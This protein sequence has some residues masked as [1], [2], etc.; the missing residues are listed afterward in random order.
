MSSNESFTIPD[1]HPHEQVP[2]VEPTTPHTTDILHEIRSANAQ[3]SA[4]LSARLDGLNLRLGDVERHYRMQHSQPDS[5]SPAARSLPPSSHNVAITARLTSEESDNQDEVPPATLNLQRGAHRTRPDAPVPPHMTRAAAALATSV[6]SPTPR[7]I[8]TTALSEL[9]PLG[10]YRTMTKSEKSN[11]RRALAGIGLTVSTLAALV[12]V[13]EDDDDLSSAAGQADNNLPSS[14][15]ASSGVASLRNNDSPIATSSAGPTTNNIGIQASAPDLSANSFEQPQPTIAMQPSSTVPPAITPMLH[16]DPAPNIPVQASTSTSLALSTRSMTCKT[17][18][19]GDYD[20]DPTQLEDFLTRLRDLIRSET[21]EELIPVWIKAV[22]RTLPRTFKSNAAVWHQGL[23]DTDAA[24]LTSFEAWATAMRAAFPVNRQQ[25]RRDA[26]LRKWK[27]NE[28]NA[29]GYYFHKVRLLRQAFGK[30]QQEEALVTDIVDGLPETM[31]ALLRLPRKGAT[32]AELVMELGDWEPNWRVQYK[33]PLRSTIA[34]ATTFPATTPTTPALAF[35]PT[36][37]RLIQQTMGRSASAP[38]TPAATNSLSSRAAPS[39]SPSQKPISKFA[40]AYDPTRVIP[41]QNGQPR[42]YRPPGKDAVMDL[43]APCS[44]C[45]GDHFNFEHDHLVPQVR[46]LVADDDDYEEYTWDGDN[47]ENGDGGNDEPSLSLESGIAPSMFTVEASDEIKP[48]PSPNDDVAE[49]GLFFTDRS[50]F[51]VARTLRPNEA[52]PPLAQEK[53][54]FG[55]VVSLSKQGATGTGQG[56][57]NHVPLTTHVRI[58]DTDGRAMSSLLDTGASL[59]CIDATLLEKMG[60]KPKGEPMSVHGIGSSRTLGW[61]TLPLFIAAQDPMGKH[62]HLEV[63]HDFHVLPFFPPGLCLGLDFIDAH[64]ISISPVRGRARLG[65]YTFQVHEKLDKPF[66]AE[67]EL[68]TSTDITIAPNTQAWVQVNAAIL[69]PD[70]DYIAVPRFSATPD[71]SV[72]LTGPNGLITHGAVRQ[73]LIGNYG[74]E[75]F[76][77]EKDTIIAD[78]AAA[79]VGD[80]VSAAG[81]TFTLDPRLPPAD[82]PPPPTRPTTTEDAAMPFDPFEDLDA[83]GPSLAQDAATTLVDGAFKVGLDA[84]GNAHPEIVQLLQDQKAAF[85]LDGRPGRVEGHDM[86]IH[87]KPDAAM[88]SE[89]PRRASPEKRA[90]MDAAIDQLLE[91]DVIEASDSPVSFPVVMVKQQS[92]WRFCVDYRNLN[93]D[94]IPDRYPLPTID[95]I[96]HTLCGKKIFSSLDA[97]RGYHQLGVQ[98]EDR[99]KTAFVCHRGLF[100]YK[101]IPFGLRNAP[102]F[103]QRFMDKV[104]GPLR[105][106]QAVVYIDDSVVAT[107][108]MAEH[109]SALRQLFQSA[110]SVGLKFSPAKCTFAVPSLVLLGRKVSGAGVAIWK[111]RAQAVEH[112]A[113]PTTLQELYHTLGL[114]GYYR[115]FIP[116]FAA[117]ASPLTALLKGW[118]YETS[119]GQSRLVNTE[120]KA[121]TASRIP[122]AWDS[123]Q[124]A[125][126][127]ALKAAITTPPVLAH[128]DP[129]KPYI[130]YTDA[131]KDALGAILHQV[132]SDPLP[133]TSSSEPGTLHVMSSPLLPLDV[134]RRSWE[135]WLTADPYFGPILRQVRSAPTPDDEWVL[136]DGV[137]VRRLDDCVALPVAAVPSVMRAV[138]D[139]RGHFGFT[140]TLLAI[141]RHFWRPSLSST[142]RA[143]VKHCAVCQRIK[144]V[145]KVGSL[146]ISNDPTSPLEAISFDLIYGFPRAQSGNDAVLAIHCLFSRMLL[147][148]PCHKDITAEGVAAIVADRV[149]RLG[150]RPKR[151]VADSEAR[152]S[153]AVMASLAS[154]LG[155]D[156]TPSSPHHQQ[157]NAVE[158]AIQTAQQ[159]LQVMAVD[160]K[161]HW[162]KRILPAVELAINS[163]PSLTTGFRP[164]DLV[165]L[166]HPDVVHALFDSQEHLGVHSFDERLAAGA[167]R[168]QEAYTAIN[169]ARKDQRRYDSRRAAIPALQPGMQAW[170]RLR[171]RPITGVIH[172]KL[173]PRKHGPFEVVEVLSPHRVRLSLPADYGIDDVFNVEQLDFLPSIADPF[174]DVRVAPP[175]PT[176][177]SPLVSADG[178]PLEDLGAATVEADETA[179]V[180]PSVVSS[181]P[182]R[183]RRPPGTLR[184]FQLGTLAPVVSEDVRTALR[185]PIVR[186]RRL[187]VDGQDMV[188]VERP[189]AFLSRLTGVAERKLVAPELELVC[190][191]WAF[192]KLAHILEGASVTVVTDHAPMERMLTSTA[193][194]AYGPTI[195]RCRALLLPHLGNLRF[196]YR[197]GPR[198]TNV[199]ALSRLPVDQGRSS[200]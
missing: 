104:L 139:D 155:A 22:L 113:R 176:P 41:A 60:G 159:V 51:S 92:K 53:R 4:H 161:A 57:R 31:V 78:A 39:G 18:W 158:R 21:Q 181:P 136:Q 56:Y 128:P 188:F 190:L 103:F 26:R 55:R 168:L 38:T 180:S 110:E 102:S 63:D 83:T 88:R 8:S 54:A 72:F 146:D 195:T 98:S 106:N 149:L 46:T 144:R 170:V 189:V 142:V 33:I 12:P 94:T 82:I 67:A 174:V 16:I 164:F 37:N 156:L 19:I 97:I 133:D 185:G 48:N 84:Q 145:P 121:V 68:R 123:P 197:P 112:L 58:N 65:R 162:D 147:L 80:S 120:G 194:V 122:I 150:W 196:V 137:L 173:D 30:D 118:R 186:P 27:P 138:H 70:V 157:A 134:A 131:S 81:E 100:Q 3:L 107:N 25:L 64:A 178:M 10:R 117:L 87:L 95:S 129:T 73:I 6:P 169:A 13:P 175:A 50:I 115:A 125:S 192:H 86:P 141:R 199:D 140:K 9:D 109:I 59:S 85:A 17:E 171:D 36:A 101:R 29:V 23:S 93:S 191:A 75:S 45:G 7:P 200:S 77:L 61:I 151:L 198:H 105:W 124:Q 132:H 126:F 152:V 116:R 111:D 177:V 20:G 167:E 127:D 184:D 119:D 32:L 28:E 79:R 49:P 43:R 11:V 193:G 47:E 166:S 24:H 183:T 182:P 44:Y 96:F 66:T 35:T 148:T 163:T 90:A 130:L 108:T 2:V 5:P 62:V 1:D 76:L 153:G 135:A 89:A 14:A 42:R 160:S 99:W 69:A 143:W 187:C 34:P 52:A 165:F 40:A 154:S 172:D 91:W 74:T 114:F 71:Q 15:G 179:S